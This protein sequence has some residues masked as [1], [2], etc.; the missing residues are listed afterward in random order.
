MVFNNVP[1]DVREQVLSALLTMHVQDG[2]W[3][4]GALL[5]AG[6]DSDRVVALV[7]SRATRG[8]R[9]LAKVFEAFD[10]GTDAGRLRNHEA[11]RWLGM[12]S[13]LQDDT[14]ALLETRLEAGTDIEELIREERPRHG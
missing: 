12:Y 11:K 6:I 8:E 14:L 1:G 5:S 13:G 7:R 3:L 9:V 4:A 10:T 2:L